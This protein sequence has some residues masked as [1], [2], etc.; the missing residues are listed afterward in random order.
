MQ[1]EGTE[2]SFLAFLIGGCGQVRYMERILLILVIGYRVL[3]FINL[4]DSQL[5]K[6]N[7]H[8]AIQEA[9]CSYVQKQFILILQRNI[10]NI[11]ED[12]Q[13]NSNPDG[14]FNQSRMLRIC[15]YRFHDGTNIIIF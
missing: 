9:E 1:E 6:P 5:I 3:L 11:Q 8:T 15:I 13:S 12:T 7:K 2:S 10:E 4:I 14:P